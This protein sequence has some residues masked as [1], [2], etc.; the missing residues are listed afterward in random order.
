MAIL[1]TGRWWYWGLSVAVVGWPS[2]VLADESPAATHT[3]AQIRSIAQ[4]RYDAVHS[5]RAEYTVNVRKLLD[6]PSLRQTNASMIFGEGNFK[7]AFWG[8]RRRLTVD[9]GPNVKSNNDP[10]VVFNGE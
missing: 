2:G 8:E 9:W 6:A 1:R 3:L 5:L 7:F 4:E 10:T